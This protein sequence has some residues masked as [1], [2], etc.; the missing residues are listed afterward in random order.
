MPARANTRSFDRR[1]GSVGVS[2]GA[3][4][5]GAAAGAARG[6]LGAAAG[7]RAARIDGDEHPTD[8]HHVEWLGNYGCPKF[9]RA[10]SGIVSIVGSDIEHPVWRDSVLLL[11]FA[12]RV[13]SRRGFPVEFEH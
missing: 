1:V 12:Q 10:T 13:S 3:A 8:I 11:I 2:A 5:G 7:W 4:G 6:E 9:L